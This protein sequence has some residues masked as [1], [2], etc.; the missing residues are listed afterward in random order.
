MVRHQNQKS[1]TLPTAQLW[2]IMVCP[3]PYVIPE[4]IDN[5]VRWSKLLATLPTKSV[6][7]LGAFTRNT[8][9]KACRQSD[10]IKRTSLYTKNML[11]DAHN[12]AVRPVQPIIIKIEQTMDP[13]ARIT[14]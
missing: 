2:L 11:Q 4:R 13:H 12:D 14:W 6:A 10:S 3:T 5:V 1:F 7:K 9:R 8:S